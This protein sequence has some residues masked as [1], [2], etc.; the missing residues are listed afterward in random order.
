MVR[1]RNAALRANGQPADATVAGMDAKYANLQQDL[2][3]DCTLAVVGGRIVAYARASAEDLTS[4]ERQAAIIIL[5][6]PSAPE[7]SAGV[8]MV[9]SR[10]LRRAM[11]QLEQTG[12]D[13]LRRILCSFPASD[14]TSRTAAEGAGFRAAR[15]ETVLV[16]DGL[17]DIPAVVL[18]EG[19]AFAPVDP[20]DRSQQ[21]RVVDEAWRA[22]SDRFGAVETADEWF[23]ATVDAPGFDPSLWRVV[24]HGGDVVGVALNGTEGSVDD[25]SRVGWTELLA[26]D[27]PYR[28]AGLGRA[29]LAGSLGGFREVGATSAAVMVDLLDPGHDE[30]TFTS[31]G[32]RIA[33]ATLE[34]LAGP[35]E[36]GTSPK[37]DDGRITTS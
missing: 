1:V 28:A 7:H 9:F 12:R 24:V 36:P 8:E 26:I 2:T 19:F 18:P 31:L 32:Y 11:E 4:G 5:A 27:A 34:Y 37:L 15:R 10:S 29:L 13:R 35:F 23:G 14:Q 3:R 33:S 20:S 6:D 16:R 25:G 21:R 22:A 30:E 17:A